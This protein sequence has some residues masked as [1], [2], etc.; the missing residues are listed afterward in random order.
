AE[1]CRRR[2]LLT[3]GAEGELFA[4]RDITSRKEA[5]ARLA[6]LALHDSLTDMPNRRFFMELAQKNISLAQR[7]GERFALLAVDLDDFKLINDIHGHAA[8]DELIRVTAKRI[9]ATV[10]DADI[11]ARFGGD[12]FAIVQ[13]CAS[14]PHLAIALAERLL[15][16]LRAPV[17]LDGA[18]VAVS[19]SIGVAL[20]PD[21]GSTVQ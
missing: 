15:D 11:S 7:T 8:G 16:V 5:E 2:I 1:I 3:D 4:V 18:E 13:T 14:Q 9:A 10:R 19:V 21:D 6:H 17:Y 12:E 20:F